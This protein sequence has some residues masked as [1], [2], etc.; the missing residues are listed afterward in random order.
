MIE[1]YF[2]PGVRFIWACPGADE[3]GTKD[4]SIIN[5][6]Q[7]VASPMTYDGLD[8]ELFLGGPNPRSVGLIKGKKITYNWLAYK[9]GHTTRRLLVGGDVLTGPMSGC[10][11]AEWT[12]NGLRYVGHVGTVVGNARIN[13]RVKQT[14][15]IALPTQARGFYPH[16][17]WPPNAI[18]PLIS[19][20]SRLPRFK[21][22]AL[23]TSSVGFY[24]I[25]MFE[26]LSEGPNQWCVG[27]IKRV[28]PM[29]VV[30]F[31]R[32]LLDG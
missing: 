18:Q 23:V 9:T 21:I 14:I 5:S 6:P 13:R 22:M 26:L 20:F 11:I 16:T 7:I 17:A 31:R 2:I 29:N 3:S 10:L 30:E 15:G 28:A 32:D 4:G 1:K 25:L 19:K 8:G 27:G 12:D 24:S